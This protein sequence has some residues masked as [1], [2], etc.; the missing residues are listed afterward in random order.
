MN[1]YRRTVEMLG[2]AY[3]MFPM[4]HKAGEYYRNPFPMYSFERASTIFWQGFI[5]ELFDRG[6]NEE[7]V[8][9]LLRSK[10]MR[11]MFDSN[12]SHLEKFAASMVSDSLIEKV[13]K[14]EKERLNNEVTIEAVRGGV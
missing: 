14:L 6:L 10:N 9:W 5:Q 7:Q 3:D 13:M 2:R 12:E 11:W 8:E 1:N 4:K